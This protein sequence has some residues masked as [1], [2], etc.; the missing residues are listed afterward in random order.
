MARFIF[1]NTSSGQPFD[2]ILISTCDASSYG[3]DRLPNGVT[4]NPG[5]SYTW[6]ISAGCYDVMAGMVGQG[7]TPGERIQIPAGRTF[8]LEYNGRG[9]SESN[10]Q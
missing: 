2:T 8:V 3:L 1:E 4:I 5:E 10:V 7:Q 6:D 9:D